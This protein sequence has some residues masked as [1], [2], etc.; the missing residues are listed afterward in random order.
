MKKINF[1][2]EKTIDPL[3]NPNTCLTLAREAQGWA[4]V[5]NVVSRSVWEWRRAV[6]EE[7]GGA[8]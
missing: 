8:G 4:Y 7:L 1:K 3:T 2:T 5:G 6:R